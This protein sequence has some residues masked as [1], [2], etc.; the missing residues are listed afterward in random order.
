[1]KKV[2]FSMV[3]CASFGGG[4]YAQTT[5]M[6]KGITME[7]YAKAKTYDIK[8]PDADDYA[9]FGENQYIA[10]RYEEKKPYFITGDDGKRKRIDLYSLTKKGDDF[11]LGTLVYYTT[12]TGKRYIACIPN[13][14]SDG[15]VW[16]EYFTDI[17]AIDKVEPFFILKLS[18]VLSKEFSYQQYKATL[19]GAAVNRKEE[20]TYGNDICFPGT[21]LVA[22]AD[23]SHKM[24]RDIKTGDHIVT[25]DAASNTTKETVVKALVSHKAENY[26]IT[27]L[28]MLNVDVLKDG[29]DLH[30]SVQEVK[31]TPN[32]PMLTSTGSKNI[33][34]IEEGEKVICQNAKTG[35]LEAFQVWDKKE[36]AEGVQQVY[37]METTEGNTFLMNGVMVRQK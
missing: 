3:L 14:F 25:V 6:P 1:M 16:E 34:T 5:T 12:E 24:V 8:D 31:A 35:K 21:D 18:Y 17:H 2:F 10:E 13:N 4:L 20:G 9:K 30:I 29:H 32:H 19:K 27:T 22:M 26:A 15:K 11:P 28:T 33:G 23:G 36:S 37:N 7:Q